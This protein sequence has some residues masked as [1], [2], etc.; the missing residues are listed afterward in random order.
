MLDEKTD[1]LAHPNIR[2]TTDGG[3][4]AYDHTLTPRAKDDVILDPDRYEDYE[5]L[6]ADAILEN[7]EEGD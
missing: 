2:M 5:I 6:D 1:L 7:I 4:P 3:A